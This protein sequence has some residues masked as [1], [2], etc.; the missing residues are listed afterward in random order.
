MRVSAAQVLGQKTL[1][2]KIQDPLAGGPKRI[3][4]FA[5]IEDNAME[6]I[7]EVLMDFDLPST[8]Q[9]TLGAAKG[10]TDVNT[11]FSKVSGVIPVYASFRSLSGVQV[12]FELPIPICRGEFHKPSIIIVN[13][14]KYVFSQSVVDKMITNTSSTVPTI[15]NEFAP[16]KTVTHLEN[17]KKE[18]FDIPDPNGVYWDPNFT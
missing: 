7:D 13:G 16:K 17:I 14:R 12:R 4:K 11:D 1:Y 10:F 5:E 18:L 3:S 15:I 8:P 6:F 9:I 2:K